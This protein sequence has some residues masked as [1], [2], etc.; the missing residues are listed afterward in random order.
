MGL[1]RQLLRLLGR[2]PRTEEGPAPLGRGPSTH[3]IILDGT[4]STLEPGC[5]TNAG[6]LYKLLCE[7][8]SSTSLTVYYEAG[9]QWRSW[10]QTWDVATGRGIN[11]QIMRAYGVLASRYREGDQIVLCGYSRGAYAVRSLAGVIETVGLVRAND[12]TVRNIRTAYQ[13]YRAGGTSEAAD[14]F[15]RRFCHWSV[16]VEAVAVWDTVKSLGL[17]LPL[18]WKRS[19]RSHAFH[20]H[21]LGRTVRHGFHALALHERRIA[22]T[23]VLWSSRPG[24]RIQQVWF[25]GTHADVGGQLNGRIASRPLSNLPLVWMIEQLSACGVPMPEG[26]ASRFPCDPDAPSTG[27]WAGWSKM[28]LARK[29]R[30]VG[31]DPSEKIHP[32]AKGH[33]A[34]QDT[35]LQRPSNAD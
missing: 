29:P 11:R 10:A 30:I 19:E 33:A 14:A 4:M 27:Q 15:R 2:L 6:L 26:W 25:A 24:A 34:D 16:E 3:V 35:R 17:R 23:P 5:E 22:Y 9:L 18:V 31:T 20:N 21:A 12:A 8:G 28:F 13:H 32:S 1:R 7:V